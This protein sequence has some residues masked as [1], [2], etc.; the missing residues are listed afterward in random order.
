MTRINNR[1]YTRR[2]E[3]RS[4]IKSPLVWVGVQGQLSLSFN[5]PI[6]GA[7]EGIKKETVKGFLSNFVKTNAA[8]WWY[9]LREDL[10]LWTTQTV[11]VVKLD[12]GI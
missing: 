5:D 12:I 7:L 2:Q 8:R 3:V 1:L 4:S 6:R 11:S 10:F 9:C